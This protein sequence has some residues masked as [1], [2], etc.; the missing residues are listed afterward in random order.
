VAI[1]TIYALVVDFGL[2]L[3]VA[4]AAVVILAAAFLLTAPPV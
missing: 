3:S 1:R 2:V 4:G